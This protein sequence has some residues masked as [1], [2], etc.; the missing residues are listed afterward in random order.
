VS[1]NPRVPSKTGGRDRKAG[2]QLADQPG[3]GRNERT[4]FLLRVEGRNQ[5]L[6][7]W[8]SGPHMCA[9]MCV[10]T[11]AHTRH[12]YNHLKKKSYKKIVGWREGSVIRAL[13]A[14]PDD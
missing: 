4:T 12:S 2:Q 9:T 1:F 10:H 3:S 5:L 14:F 7:N 13:T 6:K 11:G 8:S